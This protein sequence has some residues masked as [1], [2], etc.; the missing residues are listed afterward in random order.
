MR[1]GAERNRAAVC[2]YCVK[3][4][5]RREMGKTLNRGV[6][7]KLGKRRETG[8]VR[9]ASFALNWAKRGKSAGETEGLA[10]A[11]FNGETEVGGDFLRGVVSALDAS[12]EPDA[13][14][15][16][17]GEREG[18]RRG[19]F[20]AESAN[21]VESAQVILR[22][23]VWEAGDVRHKRLPFDAEKRRALAS[24]C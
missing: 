10:T 18:R 15:R 1:G 14:E 12:G 6:G 22:R 5:K 3:V 13:F 21:R 4:G 16:V 8:N 19:E 11:F 20:F 7:V 23:R 2:E 24:F 17:S 9:T